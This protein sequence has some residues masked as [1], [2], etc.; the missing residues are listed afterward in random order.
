[1][2]GHASRGVRK[3]TSS[4]N[5]W[6]PPMVTFGELSYACSC[7]VPFPGSRRGVS[8]FTVTRPCRW[9]V[10]ELD[11]VQ[12]RHAG[13]TS[14]SSP[15]TPRLACATRFPVD[16]VGETRHRLVGHDVPRTCGGTQAPGLEI[17]VCVA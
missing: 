2:G 17:W 6:M 5:F 3:Q 13:V 14:T 16:E 10:A 1:M 7:T 12:A 11:A 4:V 15:L 8:M 9:R